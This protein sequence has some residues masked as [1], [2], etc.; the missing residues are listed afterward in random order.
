MNRSSLIVALFLAAV[1]NPALACVLPPPPLPLPGES[2]DAYR[3]RSKAVLE[4][5]E[6]DL[7]LNFQ[8]KLMDS[9]KRV[10]IGVIIDRGPSPAFSLGR[11]ISARP[12]KVIKGTPSTEPVVLEDRSMTDCGPIGGGSAPSAGAIGDYVIVF[13]GP[14]LSDG[15]P[16]SGMLVSE[17]RDPRLLDALAHFPIATAK[18]RK[19]QQ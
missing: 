10:S 19:S 13:E 9:A 16:S 12:L 17:A 7:Q 5:E 18:S 8:A 2:P 4:S 15:E 1:P 3:I 6:R 14:A 11:R